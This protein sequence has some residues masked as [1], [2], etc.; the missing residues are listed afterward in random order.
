MI[1][2]Y[3]RWHFIEYQMMLPFVK[4]EWGIFEFVLCSAIFVYCVGVLCLKWLILGWKIETMKLLGQY[5]G[6]K[7]F[8]PCQ[9]VCSV[10]Q[11]FLTRGT[12]RE[13]FGRRFWDFR[14]F[15]RQKR[16][17]LGC[18]SVFGHKVDLSMHFLRKNVRKAGH[19][20]FL[21]RHSSKK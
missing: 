12:H 13:Y 8:G 1:L 10:S 3:E 17:S 20:G 19:S 18:P 15:V 9:S 16:W 5:C 2:Y 14:D 21:A 4:F 11:T 7:L 6:Q